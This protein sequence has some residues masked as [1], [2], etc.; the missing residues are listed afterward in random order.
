ML[1]TCECDIISISATDNEL[2]IDLRG[3]PLVRTV[4]K[5]F[6]KTNISNPLIR[7]RACAYQG[8]RNVSFLETFAYVLN[9]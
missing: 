5:S 2:L 9:E 6:R 4:R 8:V 1:I 7:T 3:H